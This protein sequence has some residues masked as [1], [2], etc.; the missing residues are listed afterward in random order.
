MKFERK[1]ILILFTAVISGYFFG[2]LAG[3][4]YNNII[5]QILVTVIAIILVDSLL[6]HILRKYDF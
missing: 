2:N 4:V 5:L 3:S 6:S 1:E